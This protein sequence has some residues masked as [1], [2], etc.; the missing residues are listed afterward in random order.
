MEIEHRRMEV[1]PGLGIPGS[2]K[3]KGLGYLQVVLQ[4]L[5]A[6]QEGGAG[7]AQV[8]QVDLQQTQRMKG[9]SWQQPQPPDEPDHTGL[10]RAPP[11]S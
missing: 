7:L 4:H 1:E 11:R 9:F 10:H 3:G 2:H 5:P 6:V 8:T